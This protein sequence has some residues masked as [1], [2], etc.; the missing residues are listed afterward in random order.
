MVEDTLTHDERIRLE[1]VVQSIA[2]NGPARV[3]Q[4][5]ADAESIAAFIRSGNKPTD[6]Q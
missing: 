4:I 5:I 1:A 3:D 2:K 6:N